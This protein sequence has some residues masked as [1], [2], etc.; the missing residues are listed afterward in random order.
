MSD[1]DARLFPYVFSCRCG[2]E[3][4]VTRR[5]CI[6]HAGHLS[7]PA[8]AAEFTLKHLHGWSSV[9]RIRL[10]CPKCSGY[11]AGQ[12]FSRTDHPSLFSERG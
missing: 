3:Q 12:D 11:G 2:A 10:Q 5:D 7:R 6:D 1:F 4:E 8:E 9:D